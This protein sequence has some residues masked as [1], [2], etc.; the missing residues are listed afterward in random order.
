VR[1]LCDLYETDR[2]FDLVAGTPLHSET[3]HVH[4]EVCGHTSEPRAL[5]I[6]HLSIQR[7]GVLFYGVVERLSARSGER[8]S[9]G[10][11]RYARP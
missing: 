1:E 2:D 9:V 8:T 11:G 5:R 3:I 7:R 10:N 4:S 6:E